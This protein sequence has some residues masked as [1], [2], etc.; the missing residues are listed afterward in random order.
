M[1]RTEAKKGL[2]G[3]GEDRAWLTVVTADKCIA[4]FVFKLPGRIEVRPRIS[5]R[6][7]Q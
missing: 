5:E 4:I 3:C 7:V 6:C 1:Y 2:K